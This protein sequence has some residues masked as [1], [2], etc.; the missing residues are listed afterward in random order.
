[1]GDKKFQVLFEVN[2]TQWL[3]REKQITVRMVMPWQEDAWQNMMGSNPGGGKGLFII[4]ALN[5]VDSSSCC[6]YLCIK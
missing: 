1:M 4:S 5:E 2:K 3:I 6:V